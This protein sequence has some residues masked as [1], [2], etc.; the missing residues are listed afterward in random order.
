M[1]LKFKV[2]I[3]ITQLFS[4]SHSVFTVT[5]M[6]R[7]A[8]TVDGEE[9]LREGKLNMVDLAGSENIGR[10]GAVETRAREAGIA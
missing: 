10:S 7:D 8:G 3:L 9:L 1:D 4:R 5:M 6:I 2:S